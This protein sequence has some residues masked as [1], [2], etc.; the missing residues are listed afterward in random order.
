MFQCVS[1]HVSQLG[2]WVFEP[3]P[4]GYF[5]AENRD[6]GQAVRLRDMRVSV[7]LMPL[8]GALTKEPPA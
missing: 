1:P 3:K 2:P 6:P 8:P 5:P 4:M 7:H